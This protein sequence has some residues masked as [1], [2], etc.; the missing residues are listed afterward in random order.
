MSLESM[1]AGRARGDV[2]MIH[3]GVESKQWRSNEV[4][5]EVCGSRLLV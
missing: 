1:F 5:D 3:G 4:G 2:A